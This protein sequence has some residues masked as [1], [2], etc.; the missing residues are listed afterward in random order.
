MSSLH[1]VVSRVPTVIVIHTWV[2]YIVSG[3]CFGTDRA[4]MQLGM[5]ICDDSRHSKFTKSPDSSTILQQYQIKPERDT[6]TKTGRWTIDHFFSLVGHT[7]IHHALEAPRGMRPGRMGAPASR[8]CGLGHGDF[9]DAMDDLSAPRNRRRPINTPR[10]L[11]TSVGLGIVQSRWPVGRWAQ[12]RGV[13][14]RH[15]HGCG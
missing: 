14:S 15:W 11:R 2:I 10:H 1:V 12:P 5:A 7:N 6:Q 13:H 3:H 9:M 8:P 4:L